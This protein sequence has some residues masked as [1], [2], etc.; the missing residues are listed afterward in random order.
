MKTV[1]WMVATVVLLSACKDSI[2]DSGVELV[3]RVR[4]E[5]KTTRVLLEK[6]R[7][8][9]ARRLEAME[10]PG[11]SVGLDEDRN[12]IWVRIPGGKRLGRVKGVCAQGGEL[13][14]A[15]VDDLI[16]GFLAKLTGG[17]PV[18]GQKEGDMALP[19]GVRI[20]SETLFNGARVF[21]LTAAT[22]VALQEGIRV[23]SARVPSG[24]KLLPS[25]EVRARDEE[26][27]RTYL[28]KDKA[29]PAGEYIENVE[30]FE[31]EI[32]TFE[33][34]FK[35]KPQVQ[36]E[37]SDKGKKEF[38]ELTGR[39]VKQRMAIVLDGCVN[40]APVVQESITGGRAGITMGGPAA[41]RDTMRRQ[42]EI[43]AVT[44]GAGALPA[45]LELVK[46]RHF[47]ARIS[48][49]NGASGR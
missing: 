21:Y 19:P 31:G 27:W 47:G 38:G 40:S 43:L 11:A 18:K 34:K 49:G 13:L 20:E 45:P 24:R 16:T 7:A 6:T 23:V 10:L 36:I 37:F 29:W 14:F 15:E 4:A 8:V 25:R 35:A 48:G 2:P 26:R 28:I 44:L 1:F 42:A 5:Q 22:R 17:A 39:L 33:S 9:L 12:L 41:N 30:I 3:Y 32:T 46:E